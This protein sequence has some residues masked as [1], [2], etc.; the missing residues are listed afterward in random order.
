MNWMEMVASGAGLIC[1]WLVVKNNIWNWPIGLIQVFLYIFIFYQS[2]LYSDAGLQVFY[3]IAGIYGW[4]FWLKGKNKQEAP[5]T[6]IGLKD[7]F[8]WVLV[9]LVLTFLWGFIMKNYTD[10]AVP[11]GD[12]FIVV[13]SFIAQ[14]L[15]CKRR[16]EQWYFWIAVDIMALPVYSF[17]HLYLTTGLYAVFLGL[18]IWGLVK[19]IKLYKKEQELI[20]SK[21][22]KCQTDRGIDYK[23]TECID[24]DIDNILEG[25]A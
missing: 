13:M 19:W 24:K 23:C 18:A 3:V 6:K 4:W 16:V 11:F 14:W 8:Y 1:V 5:I 15:M 20:K 7:T 22:C 12:A 9:G 21:S 2:K 25:V 10:A 17:K